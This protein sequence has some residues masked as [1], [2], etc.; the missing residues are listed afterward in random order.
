[1]ASGGSSFRFPGLILIISAVR[2][3][4]RSAA[5]AAASR[6]RTGIGAVLAAFLATAPYA[7]DVRGLAALCGCGSFPAHRHLHPLGRTQ[8]GIRCPGKVSEAPV[9][10]NAASVVFRTLHRRE[11]DH[12]VDEYP[13]RPGSADP[14]DEDRL[15]A[16]IDR[17]A[18]D[19]VHLAARGAGYHHAR[20]A[21]GLPC[22]RG[23]GRVHPRAD[24]AG[25]RRRAWRRPV[26]ADSALV[27]LRPC[28]R[29]RSDTHASYWRDRR[30]RSRRSRARWACPVQ[31]STSTS[32]GTVESSA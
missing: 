7:T 31:P 19:R 3:Q 16:G 22:V 26:L 1:M 6:A 32:P 25:A 2:Q 11:R 5:G 20:R 18:R 30:T 9:S 24:N 29:S 8:V 15:C 28:P 10:N 12:R 4:A 23:P 21:A 14:T 17:G 27:G 13:G